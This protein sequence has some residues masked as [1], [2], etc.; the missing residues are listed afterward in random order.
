MSRGILRDGPLCGSALTEGPL[1]LEVENMGHHPVLAV[2]VGQTLN[3]SGSQ[4][5]H[6]KNRDRKD[7]E[8]S[9]HRP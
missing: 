5:L 3:F 1:L 7:W 2:T 9:V 4:T 8:V 6:V